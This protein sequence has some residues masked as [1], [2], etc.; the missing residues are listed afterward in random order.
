[1]SFGA[2]WRAMSLTSNAS[3]NISMRSDRATSSFHSPEKSTP[4]VGP[5]GVSTKIV[6]LKVLSSSATTGLTAD[7]RM[8]A[9]ICAAAAET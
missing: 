3:K 6:S 7:R 8:F 4:S 1:M 2:A 5:S 9:Q